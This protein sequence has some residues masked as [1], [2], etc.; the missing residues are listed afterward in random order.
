M[1]ISIDHRFPFLRMTDTKVREGEQQIYDDINLS[2][3]PIYTDDG[4]VRQIRGVM[5]L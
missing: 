2:H 5:E 3:E 1:T 4:Y